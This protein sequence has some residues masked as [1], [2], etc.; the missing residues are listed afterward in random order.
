M[1]LNTADWIVY[2][3][4]GELTHSVNFAGYKELWNVEEGFPSPDFF[5]ALCPKMK[6]IV[7]TKI[8]DKMA[9]LSAPA[10]YLTKEGAEL[11]GLCEGTPVATP[12][13]DAHASMPALGIVEEG[14]C[15]VI[16][17]T[18]GVYLLHSA[19]KK[20]MTGIMGYVKDGIV[21]GLYSYEAAQATC[22]DHL[23]WYINN[24]LPAEYTEDAKAQGV[25]IHKYL[26]EKAKKLRVG[27]NSDYSQNF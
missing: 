18:S 27:E 12:V 10:G 15:M 16:L 23:E 24:A 9:T 5:E 7:G 8:C 2:L 13:I 6:N 19:E 1:Y 17:G 11:V 14:T 3:L 20:D 21:E 4:T 25:K 22:G 26:R